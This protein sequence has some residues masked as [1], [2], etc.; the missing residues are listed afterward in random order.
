[1]LSVKN[2]HCSTSSKRIFFPNEKA[3]MCEFYIYHAE[4]SILSFFKHIFHLNIK[5]SV[6]KQ[7]KKVNSLPLNTAFIAQEL[8]VEGC[9]LI[10]ILKKFK[11]EWICVFYSDFHLVLVGK[12]LEIDEI[13]W[14]WPFTK[15]NHLIALENRENIWNQF[16]INVENKYSFEHWCYLTLN[17]A[18][19]ARLPINTMNTIAC[20]DVDIRYH[21]DPE[22]INTKIIVLLQFA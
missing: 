7:T 5:S 9:R 2:V 20:V 13:A 11:V 18:N 1:M 3:N 8:F 19:I 16:K 4:F 22:T 6:A 12:S 17:F 15:W 14:L 10:S 21:H